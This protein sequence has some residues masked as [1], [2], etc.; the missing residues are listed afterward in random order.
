M[1][2]QRRRR[3]L[4]RLRAGGQSTESGYAIAVVAVGHARDDVTAEVDP[5][6]ARVE[7][8]VS[9]ATQEFPGL[10]QCPWQVRDSSEFTD[11]RGVDVD[12]RIGRVTSPVSGPADAEGRAAFADVERSA[13]RN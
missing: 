2:P 8:R 1:E 10:R 4:R 12:E 7:Y 6:R 5:T 13:I 3:S 11:E 9:W